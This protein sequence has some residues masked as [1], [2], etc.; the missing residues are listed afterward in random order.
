MNIYSLLVASLTSLLIGF[1]WYNPKIFGTIWMRESGIKFDPENKP[2]MLKMILIHFICAFFIAILLR[3]LVIHQTGALAMIGGDVSNATPTFTAFMDEYGT[4]F[5][6]F[7]HGALH[8]TL[9]GIL[10]VLP[11]FSI[12][13]MYEGK[14]FKYVLVN[15]GYWTISLGVMGGIICA[16]I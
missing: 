5:R 8:G 3:F 10:F 13:A 2:N 1:V 9:T 4:V 11:L 6:T 14:S 7:K 12:T 15:S 16:W